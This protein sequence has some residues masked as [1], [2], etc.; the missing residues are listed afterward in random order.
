VG[1]PDAEQV[2]CAQ[3]AP[4]AGAAHVFVLVLAEPRDGLRRETFEI[5]LDAF[6]VEDQ[7]L[8]L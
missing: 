4:H 1:L 5:T 3:G 7:I 6:N 2:V 8:N